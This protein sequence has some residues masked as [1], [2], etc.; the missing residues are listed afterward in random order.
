MN[1]YL[2]L[3][4]DYYINKSSTTKENGIHKYLFLI[5][6]RIVSVLFESNTQLFCGNSVF[7]EQVF[8][9]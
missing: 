2:I 1:G 3:S 6:I 8:Y 5:R 7:F 9:L 4:G